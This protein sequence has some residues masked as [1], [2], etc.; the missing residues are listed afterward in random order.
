MRITVDRPKA[1]FERTDC[2]RIP[3][4]EHPRSREGCWRG[5]WDG[6]PGCLCLVAR[7]EFV[8]NRPRPSACVGGS[9]ACI[10]SYKCRSTSATAT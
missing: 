4:S 9:N 1:K 5:G 2:V 10:T 6:A 7:F 3:L 8:C